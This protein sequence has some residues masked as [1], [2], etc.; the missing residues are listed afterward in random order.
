MFFLG[1]NETY[2][3]S[4]E[5]ESSLLSEGMDDLP[6]DVVRS[7]LTNRRVE[8]YGLRIVSR[9]VYFHDSFMDVLRSYLRR[10]FV[11]FRGRGVI[12]TTT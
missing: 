12:K 11:S 8:K 9:T 1:G 3:A 6:Q 7:S 2:L 5:I 10:S 4:S